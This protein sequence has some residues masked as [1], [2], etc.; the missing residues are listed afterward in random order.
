MKNKYIIDDT[1]RNLPYGLFVALLLWGAV[2]V[3]LTWQA[4]KLKP[5]NVEF[6]NLPSSA[7]QVIVP[8]PFVRQMARQQSVPVQQPSKQTSSQT[9]SPAVST[10]AMSL[11]EANL[12]ANNKAPSDTVR[13]GP[14]GLEKHAIAT[15]KASEGPA[16]P[17]Q[18]GAA[19]LNNPKPEYPAFAR[20]MRIEGMVMLKVFVS[21]K[22]TAVKIETA[23]S[24]GYEILDKAAAGA[25]RNWRFVPAKHGDSPVDE[26]CFSD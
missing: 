11:P 2:I 8:K 6:I 15:V 24:S 1:W 21:R 14:P 13:T 5:L 25:V 16:T 18:F 12:T 17:P 4:Q 3:Q 20:R 9:R 22:G 19:Y 26:C 7:S 10:H 23:H